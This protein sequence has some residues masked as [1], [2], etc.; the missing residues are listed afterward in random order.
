M[1]ALGADD[2]PAPEER[3]LA[4]PSLAD[5][6]TATVTVI[7]REQIEVRENASVT[8][9]LRMIPGIHIDEGG[10]RGGVTSLYTRGADPNYTTVL[11][12]G[13]R[14]N[15]PTNSRGGS[16]D[17]ALLSTAN[18]E[19]I[20]VA[21]GALPASWGAKSMVGA[22]NIIT[23]RGE[24]DSETAVEAW[25]GSHGFARAE[26][27]AHGEAGAFNY[28]LALAGVDNG[29]PQEGSEFHGNT[30]ATRWGYDFSDALQLSG[31]FRYVDT[32]REAYRDGSGG[33]HF[34]PVRA[35]EDRDSKITLLGLR[36]EAQPTDRWRQTLRWGYFDGD[37]D[38]FQ[39]EVDP[40][41]LPEAD[42]STEFHR[43]EVGWQTTFALT[44]RFDL[45]G[46]VDAGF[47]DG[48]S[49]GYFVEPFFSTRVPTDFDL[50]RDGWAPYAELEA[51]PIAGLVLQVG[52]RFDAVHD[53]LDNAALD[54][55]ERYTEWSPRAAASYRI[56]PIDAV[57]RTNYGQGFRPPS[58]F[59][60]AHPTVGNP[61]LS[62][63]TSETWDIGVTKLLW[64]GRA[65]L[66]AAYYYSRFDSLIDFDSATFSLVNRDEATAYGVELGAAVQPYPNLGLRAY[67]LSTR[68]DVKHDPAK[69]KNRPDWRGGAEVRW[70]VRDGLDTSLN[71]LYVGRVRDTSVPTGDVKLD[72][73]I[74]V[75]LAITYTV[76]PGLQT[77]V[78]IENLFDHDYEEF[79]GFPAPGFIG[80]VGVRYSFT[81]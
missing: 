73:Y 70:R 44:D 13:V 12:D 5:E 54:R 47:E 59:A 40:F 10:A 29:V 26:A 9:I 80:K 46:G 22:I 45:I 65:S 39:P 33:P 53:D 57:V 37:E 52:S 78:S 7:T 16:F 1:G 11:I 35:V 58:Y 38:L 27:A 4:G 66:D 72:P 41:L 18:I 64:D 49:D 77:F 81:R 43:H 19:R 76:Q 56:A 67:A 3:P 25:G 79:V 2:V 15:D 24:G 71:A 6:S 17:F 23:R 8:E 32:T 14:V 68:T 34:S 51:R 74:R 30:V 60:L 55:T 48:S 20:E 69:L 50:D 42:T 61:R 63:E 62:A 31:T 21:R 36:A 28:S 75:D